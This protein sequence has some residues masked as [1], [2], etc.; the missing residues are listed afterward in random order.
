MEQVDEYLEGKFW[1]VTDPK[2][3]YTVRDLR[4]PEVRRVIGFLNPIFHSDR[5]RGWYL[6]GCKLSLVSSGKSWR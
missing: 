6:S 3:E 1:N 2:A 4:D 5:P